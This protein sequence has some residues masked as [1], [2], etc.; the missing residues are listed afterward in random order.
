MRPEEA[1]AVAIAFEAALARIAGDVVV[2]A[3]RLYL[4]VNA[5]NLRSSGDAWLEDAVEMVSGYGEQ[6]RLLGLAFFRLYRALMT[7]RTVNHPDDPPSETVTLGDLRD[8]FVELT[9]GLPADVAYNPPRDSDHIRIPVDSDVEIESAADRRDARE[10]RREE[11]TLI[12][13]V[14]GVDNVAKKTREI[15]LDRVT[16]RE[17]D[18]T[19][20][21]ILRKSNARQAAAA[22]RMARNGARGT[23]FRAI[24]RDERVIGYVRASRTGTPCGFCA[25]LI[26]RGFMYK[27]TASAEGKTSSAASVLAGEAAEGDQYHDNCNCYAKPVFSRAE[28]QREEYALNRELEALWKKEIKGRYSGRE[29]RR[30]WNALIRERYRNTTSRAQAA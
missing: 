17:A 15:D 14:L 21:E 6:A 26:S 10:G 23:I 3:V 20:D 13:K 8:D 28:Y 11:A 7:G 29:A 24:G 4:R 22:A 25:M 16:A 27:S 9:R 2:E 30:V 12:L 18:E 19:R 5:A 1:A